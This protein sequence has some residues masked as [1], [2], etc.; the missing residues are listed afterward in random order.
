MPALTM[1][2][3]TPRD[4]EE[5]EAAITRSIPR[6][7][8]GSSAT[9]VTTAQSIVS[10]MAELRNFRDQIKTIQ[11]KILEAQQTEVSTDPIDI[12]NDLNDF[13]FQFGQDNV[14]NNAPVVSSNFLEAV[15]PFLQDSASARSDVD[16]GEVANRLRRF[17]QE[18]TGEEQNGTKRNRS[19]T[20][21]QETP[22]SQ[23]S[24]TP[25][26]MPSYK[27]PK[28]HGFDTDPDTDLGFGFDGGRHRKSR[29][30]KKSK[31]TKRRQQRGGKHKKNGRKT[32]R[33]H[34]RRT[35]KCR[36]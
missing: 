22:G 35:M 15:E 2:A 21:S 18:D 13:T 29:H 5:L 3:L 16:I 25:K 27:K 36:K 7:S 28:G 32:M 26:R 20:G 31:K 10:S 34:K 9:S 19:P 1:P 17:A 30:H 33:R 11:D 14:I 24:Q 23:G 8:S 6:S 12:G 4:I